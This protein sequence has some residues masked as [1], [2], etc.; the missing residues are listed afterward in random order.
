[1]HCQIVIEVAAWQ[2]AIAVPFKLADFDATVFDQFGSFNFMGPFYSLVLF[3]RRDASFATFRF[4]DCIR[5]HP[6][7]MDHLGNEK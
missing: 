4:T 6:T 1:M 5:L 2:Q 7:F 3:S